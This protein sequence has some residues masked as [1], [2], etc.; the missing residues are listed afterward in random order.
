M[1]GVRSLIVLLVIAIPLGWYALRESKKEPEPDKKQEKVFTAVDADKVDQITIKSEKGERTTVQ[2]QNGKWQITAPVSA[3]ADDGE[4][5][6]LTSNLSSLQVQ[7]VVDDQAS[8]YKQYGLDPARLDVTFKVGGQDRHLLIGQKTPTGTDLYA[9]L[10]DKPRVFLISSYLD[11][12]FNKSAFDLRDKTVLK[13]DREKV[14][15]V[16]V[17]TP[18]RTLKFTKSGSDW[19][20]AAPVD[21]RADFSAVEAIIGRLN[22][23]QMK[24]ITAADGGDLKE[25]GLETPA[26]TV[27]LGSGSS[28]AGLVIGKSAGDGVIY[29]KDVSRPMIFTI[30]SAIADEL[31]K[32]ADDFRIK[33]LFDARSFNTTRVEV[34]RAG[35]TTAY[36]K[37]K[38]PAKGTE[39]PKDVWKQVVP[40]SKDVDAAKV[41]ALLTSLTNA[42]ATSFVDKA[43]P[44][45]LDTPELAVTLK[46]RGRRKTGTRRV[47]P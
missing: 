1:R 29:A 24:A 21:T 15:N 2:K 42:R 25:Y 19:H 41:D 17:A 9:R 31:K 20:M 37:S 26:V 7:R 18:E 13:I 43:T 34:V 46:Y 22:T 28:Q 44:T 40:A 4:I 8:D 36:E 38:S 6:G 27:H 47:R 3:V 12:T 33:D 5:S 10:A 16:E 39:P 30:E 11:S 45:G 23:A 35:Q 14:D 32:P